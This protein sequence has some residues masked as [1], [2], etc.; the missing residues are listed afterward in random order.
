MVFFP[1]KKGRFPLLEQDL[2]NAMA[3]SPSFFSKT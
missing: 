2:L 3:F 1:K